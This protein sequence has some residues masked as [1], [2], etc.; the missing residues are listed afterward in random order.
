MNY[1]IN[2]DMI[3]LIIYG[4]KINYRHKMRRAVNC[5]CEKVGSSLDFLRQ[6]E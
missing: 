2:F 6:I 4:I 5:N 3:Q 1:I